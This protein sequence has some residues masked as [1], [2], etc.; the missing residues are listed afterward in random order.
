MNAK[1]DS[2]DSNDLEQNKAFEKLNLSD[3]TGTKSKFPPPPRLAVSANNSYC[4]SSQSDSSTNS[5]TW[6]SNVSV[7][8][9]RRRP[10]FARKLPP[11]GIFWDIENVCVPKHKSAASLVQKIRETFLENYRESEFVVVCDVK[12]ENPQVL[13]E[14]HDS[15]VNLIHVS[16]T[17]KNAADEKLRQSLRRFA[18]V[19]PAPSAIVLISGDINFA[20]DLSD[21][22][23]RKKIKVYLV[24]Q[25]N[26]AEAL[27]FCANEHIYLNRLIQDL[28]K[29]VGKKFVDSNTVYYLEVTNLPKNIEQARVKCRLQKLTANCGGK[30]MEFTPDKS[31]AFLRFGN[32]DLA[33][34]AQKRIQGE[35][36]FGSKIKVL[37]P[38]LRS[39]TGQK[40]KNGDNRSSQQQ[41]FNTIPPP[42]LLG[43][44][45]YP[46]SLSGSE[47][48]DFGQR[49]RS[50]EPGPACKSNLFHPINPMGPP[51]ISPMDISYDQVPQF[52]RSAP[53]SRLGTPQE[54]LNAALGPYT[55]NC[56]RRV[57]KISGSSE[58][59]DSEPKNFLLNDSST[60]IQNNQP[61]DLNITNLDPNI[62]TKELR[63]L[64]GAMIKEYVMIL[65][66]NVV[67]QADGTPV[68][69]LRVLNAHDAQ[70]VISQ[71][72]R[73]KL[74]H[75][76]IVISY[77][78]N[79]SPDPDQLKIMVVNILQDMPEK[80]MPLFKF[81]EQLELKYHC[82]VSVSEVN[83]LKDSVKIYDEMGS[84]MISLTQEAKTNPT[85][86]LSQM[87][88]PYCIIH[89]P[90]G[91]QSRG[92]FELN[93]GYIPSVMMTLSLFTAKLLALLSLHMGSM[94]LLSFQEC[95]EQ[96]YHES[97]PVSESGVPLEHLVTCVPNVEIKLVGSNKNVK[98]IQEKLCQ[99]ENAD[100]QCR[101]APSLVPNVNLLCREVVD[102]LKTT[103]KC[104]LLLTKFIP[105]YHHHF[106]RQ[107][108]VADYGY[109]KLL[110]LFESI[111]HV[112]QIMGDGTRRII[113]LTHSAQIRR[114]TSDLLRVLKVQP[115]KQ[116]T[117]TAFPAAYEK[118]LNKQFNPVEYGLCTFDDLLQEVSETTVVITR[119]TTDNNVFISVPKREQT[120]EE[121]VRTKQFAN[122]IKELPDGERIVCLTLDQSLKILGSQVIQL[123]KG[124]G[125][126]SLRVDDFPMFY[127]K[128][129]NYPL[130][131][132]VYQ[133]ETIVEV[134]E[135]LSDY[136][137]VI[138]SNGGSLLRPIDMDMLP[139]ILRVRSWALLLNPPHVKD[140]NTFKYEYQCS[141]NSSF[142]MDAIRDISNVVTIS[143]MNN[144]EFISLTALYV[145]AAQLYYVI[146][147]NGG[148]VLFSQL[149]KLYMEH[150]N[151][152]IKLSNFNI[153]SPNELFNYFS[154]I[155]FIRSNKKK[156]VV[157]LNRNLQEQLTPLTMNQMDCNLATEASD[158]MERQNHWCV[159]GGGSSQNDACQGAKKKYSPPKPDTP[160]TPGS[161][162][163]WSTPS[164]Y[165]G[166]M[167]FSVSVPISLNPTLIG[168]TEHLVSPARYLTS[169]PW[170][171]PKT[172]MVPPEPAEL[173][174]PD[175][176]LRKN[177]LKE[178]MSDD[179]ADSG[180]NIKLDN[181]PSDYEFESSSSDNQG[182]PK[183]LYSTFLNFK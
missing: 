89:C 26:V 31:V 71:L 115:N 132:Q 179:S 158:D 149:E 68:A 22:R 105:A 64:L 55:L 84:R 103:E 166:S 116:I 142:S 170:N 117:F 143:S 121:I 107:C 1:Q 45:G 28:P 100:D 74:G 154:S 98:I 87:M 172:L 140:F 111:S 156:S 131:P 178:G 40:I 57:H 147:T 37:S 11:M 60:K 80:R 12:K 162:S 119:S 41:P 50:Q 23:Y 32:Y 20:G 59:S 97:L 54:Q 49:R 175:K 144:M 165:E 15:Q 153:N 161:G 10:G 58:Q 72:H 169:N 14:L 79:N 8:K 148:S 42:P 29:S 104:Q 96:E 135:K 114:F 44:G 159:P 82:T 93:S 138:H 164:K 39:Y 181:S 127:F 112:V 174:L 65:H 182:V 76:R 73:Q 85:N 173:P 46:C 24:H 3:C 113:T 155:F 122:E 128:E 134:V 81:M 126:G 124:P 129:Y 25:Q 125:G 160:P 109:T 17:S 177:L 56:S 5:I 53:V 110:D 118:V 171:S 101:V 151:K 91:L 167:S 150:Y 62:E 6:G 139:D 52:S 108:R 27:I 36:V 21:L 145:L 176:L 30:C 136:V 48:R 83:K 34:R 183:K 75:K 16:S 152:P 70:Y 43:F 180:V 4:C 88:V 163:I 94:P 78:Q 157:V 61:V 69:N 51:P 77:T 38:S 106:G 92:F 99:S 95:Y 67:V 133:C 168:N 19:N 120:S 86:N 146:C 123:I 18:E 2:S 33:L 63:R 90:K 7:K 66:L 13:Q 137:Q 141:Y 35:D 102:L 47:V 9:Y 130:N